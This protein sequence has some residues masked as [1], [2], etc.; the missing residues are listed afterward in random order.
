LMNWW[1]PVPGGTS[2]R[3]MKLA[4]SL[5]DIKRD[6]NSV[7][8]VGTFD[9]VHRA[10]QEIIREVVQ[11][12]RRIEGRSVVVTFDPHPR[13]VLGGNQS[14]IQLLSTIE[15]RVEMFRELHVDLTYII[16]FTYEFSRLSPL[17]FYRQHVINGI[18]VCEVVV[19][20]D[21]HF[22]RDR[23]A[24]VEGLIQMGKEFNFS[25]F[26][27]HPYMVDG[28]TVSSTRIRAALQEGEVIKAWKFLG[29]PYRLSGTV[30]RGDGRGRQLGYPTANIAP[31]LTK[32]A[33]PANGVY[34]VA[35]QL[36]SE[37]YYGMMNI[38]VRPTLTEGAERTAEV[39]ILEFDRDIYGETLS[40]GF[41]RRLRE[42][43]KFSSAQDLI[44][45]LDRD[46]SASMELVAAYKGKSLN[47]H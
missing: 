15:E 40:V 16:N 17:E 24:G 11:R 46:R 30:V 29:F 45:Q 9:G 23:T 39:H 19:G 3:S 1:K 34:L 10:H 42:E 36:G 47:I 43:R 35:V 13:E 21:H 12:A 7:V 38:G 37:N 20:Y 33:L 44:A 14:P 5:T 6:S 32:K 8:T 41:L 22:G 28:E 4:R 27:V 25:V 2:T 18:G 31:S 26:A